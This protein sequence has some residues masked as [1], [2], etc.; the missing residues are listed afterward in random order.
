MH[1]PTILE[2]VSSGWPKFQLGRLPQ[3]RF[4][5]NRYPCTNSFCSV[6]P[7]RIPYL[8]SSHQLLKEHPSEKLPT[9]F[10]EFHI[11]HPGRHTFCNQKPLPCWHLSLFLYFIKTPNLIADYQP[12]GIPRALK[13]ITDAKTSQHYSL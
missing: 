7:A 8:P 4:H 11:A 13:P 10:L 3:N 6:N 9:L 5:P 1:K 2:P 12:K